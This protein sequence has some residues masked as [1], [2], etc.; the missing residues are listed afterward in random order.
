V[1]YIEVTPGHK[2]AVICAST[3]IFSVTEIV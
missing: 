3:T 1:E 2:V